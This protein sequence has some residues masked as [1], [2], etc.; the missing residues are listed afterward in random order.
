TRLVWG[1]VGTRHARF[2]NFV[3]GAA[4]IVAYARAT[5][6]GTPPAT[7]GHNPVGALMVL[8]LLALLLAQAL[9]G[10]FASDD[11]SEFGPLL[12]LVTPYFSSL[13]TRWHHRIFDVLAVLISLHVAAALAYLFWKRVNLI[14]PMLTGYKPADQVPPGER[15]QGS[16]LWLAVAIAALFA[17]LLAWGISSA[18][19]AAPLF[20]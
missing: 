2:V 19:V 16:R 20:I 8:A 3:R 17:A 15:I 10:L 9:T 6:R 5:V 11:V 14:T 1:F 13:A 7:P 4:Q 18:P 12:G